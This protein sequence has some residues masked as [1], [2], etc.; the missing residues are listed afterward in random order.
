[1]CC[2]IH[3]Y[4]ALI[5]KW[6]ALKKKEAKQRFAEEQM[7]LIDARFHVWFCATFIEY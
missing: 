2:D 5:T 3:E 7:D 1:M 6:K 4:K